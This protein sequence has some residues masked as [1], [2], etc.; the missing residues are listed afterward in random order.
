MLVDRSQ[1][2]Q[3]VVVGTRTQSG[4]RG[5]LLGSVGLHLLHHAGCPVL[6]ARTR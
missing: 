3:L 2:A 6:I 1:G 4:L 5:M